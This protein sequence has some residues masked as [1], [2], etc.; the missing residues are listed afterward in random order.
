MPGVV[1]TCGAL[2]RGDEI[3]MYYGAADTCVGLAIG[4]VSDLLDLVTA[5][6]A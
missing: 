2:V 4:K 1:F 6:S 5:G 3:W